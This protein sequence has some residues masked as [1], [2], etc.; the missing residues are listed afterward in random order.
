MKPRISI[1]DPRLSIAK[2]AKRVF[3]KRQRAAIFARSG[4]RCDLCG[5]KIK[6]SWIA[7]HVT[8]HAL[9]GATTI[10]N[11][12]V[13][14]PS[15]AEGTHANDTGRAAKS[16]RQARETGQQAR[17]AKRG[18]SMIK[19][20]TKAQRKANYLRAKEWAKIQK[21]KKGTS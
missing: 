15:C 16:K 13:E 6:G 12:R 11:G 1:I 14:C 2:D 20:P 17:R 4:G 7:G 9:G 5:E 18:G 10:G 3:T 19:G 8:P 21:A